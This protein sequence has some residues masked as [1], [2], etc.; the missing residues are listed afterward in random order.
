MEQQKRQ[1]LEDELTSIREDFLA[2][3]SESQG[4]RT[5]WDSRLAE[6][7]GSLADSQEQEARLIG[8]LEASKQRGDLLATELEREKAECAAKTTAFQQ[9]EATETALRDELR[10]L[11][12][13][14]DEA[15]P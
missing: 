12:D 9:C 14:A 15:S 13:E 3:Q 6:L 5:V 2:Q 10:V 1:A 11:Q 8:Q 7:R 4:L